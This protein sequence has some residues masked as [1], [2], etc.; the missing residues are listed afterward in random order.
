MKTAGTFFLCI[1]IFIAGILLGRSTIHTESQVTI[2]R[3]NEIKADIPV[4]A[5][6]VSLPENPVLPVKTVYIHDTV[7]LYQAI[8]TAAIIADYIVKREYNLPVFNNELGRLSI[9]ASIQYNKLF[10]LSCDFTP[11]YK[12]VKI[13]EKT[14]WIPFVGVSYN[15]LNQVGLTGGIFYYDIGIEAG[16]SIGNDV[17]YWGIG[18][19]Y[20]F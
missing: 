16:Y 7:P 13:K 11:V 15:S 14:V 12:E 17:Q 10:D 8:D 4:P 1:I 19:K 3:G 18:V 20:K 5:P 6:V 9:D 2:V